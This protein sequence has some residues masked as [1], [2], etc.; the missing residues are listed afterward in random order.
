MHFACTSVLTRKISR[1]QY[2]EVF[3]TA[4]LLFNRGIDSP[5]DIS[6]RERM[7][8]LGIEGLGRRGQTLPYKITVD[9]SAEVA[10]R[11]QEHTLFER[12]QNASISLHN[13]NSQH[14]RRIAYLKVVA[15]K[16]AQHVE[17]THP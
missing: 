2:Y 16:A 5:Y 8:S 10:N 7:K 6:I 1:A 15:D 14:I 3:V 4:Q 13:H 12:E 17:V 11:T 9:G